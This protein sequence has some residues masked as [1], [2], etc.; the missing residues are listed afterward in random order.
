MHVEL[1][2]TGFS[3]VN[4]FRNGLKPESMGIPS[5]SGIAISNIILS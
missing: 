1:M 4:L 3:H 2:V 5:D